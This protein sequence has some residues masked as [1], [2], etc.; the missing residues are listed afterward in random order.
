MKIS[1]IG[2]GGH[3]GFPM[4]L[5]MANAGH[6]VIG[7]DNDVEKNGL[8]MSGKVPFKEDQAVEYLRR[9]LAANRLTMTDDYREV[10]TSEVIVIVIGTPIDEHLNPD[11]TGIYRVT[12]DI[13]PYISSGQLII[14]RS[15]VAPGTTDRVKAILEEKTGLRVGQGIYL[16]FA[17]ERVLQGKAIEEIRSLPQH[18][19]VYDEKSYDIAEKFFK[20]F[21]HSQCIRLSPV[22]A[23]LGKLMT[24]MARYISFALANEYYLIADT[25]GVSANKIIDA[26]NL[27]YPRMNLPRPGPNVGGPCLHK[28]GWFLLERIPYNELIATAF[29]IN[30]GMPIHIVEKLEQYEQI[31]KIAVLGM[32]FKAN[33]DD[34][35]NSV[36]FKLKK[37]LEARGYQLILVEPN[38]ENYS[39]LS[40]IGGSDA[41]IIMTPHDEF[42]SLT[43]IMDI[44][45][46]PDCLYV[47]IWGFWEEMKYRSH[48]G[49][50]WGREAKQEISK[51]V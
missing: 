31:Q 46:N 50:F 8:I 22:E 9:A 44:V 45:K 47:D 32:T 20:T 6:T 48:N 2:G 13:A 49:F 16:A 36:S 5:V 14:L 26:C 41:V 27:D 15:T 25:F 33:N 38:L 1:V 24:N 37:Q 3:V 11:L 29:R 51:E 17:P 19:G 21:I 7:I 40:E 30:E 43:E 42:R 34:I 18:V 12:K 4:C 39:P 23:E 10:E 35:R 28:D